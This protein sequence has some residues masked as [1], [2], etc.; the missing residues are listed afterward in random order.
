MTDRQPHPD[1]VAALVERYTIEAVEVIRQALQSRDPKTRFQAA[2]DMVYSYS[3]IA[4]L[5]RTV[6][7]PEVTAEMSPKEREIRMTAALSHPDVRAWLVAQGWQAPGPAA[8][9][10]PGE[11][12]DQPVRTRQKKERTG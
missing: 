5:R 12:Q 11:D 6:P 10:S 9:S 2:R 1:E 3:R 4:H 7:E 8:L